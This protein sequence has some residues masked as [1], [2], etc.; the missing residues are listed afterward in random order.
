[1]NHSK[2]KGKMKSSTDSPRNSRGIY[3]TVSN[4]ARNM[5]IDFYLAED[6]DGQYLK[7]ADSV[8]IK[9]QTARSI[10]ARFM[11]DGQRDK[12]S[13]GG[14]RRI[15]MDG[16]MKAT[17]L[18]IL[19]ENPECS[20]Q[21]INELLR[22]R[23]PDKVVSERTVGRYLDDMLLVAVNNI[24]DGTHGPTA[25][26]ECKEQER[27][28]TMQKGILD[29]AQMA[30]TIPGPPAMLE[31]EQLVLGDNNRTDDLEDTRSLKSTEQLTDGEAG[32]VVDAKEF[33]E[34]SVKEETLDA[35][36]FSEVSVKEETLDSR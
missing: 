23:L 26:S 17:L 1:M 10:I 31:G 25:T 7:Y 5:L 24:A 4:K 6:N 14:A 22:Q 18:E 15:K 33:S 12:Q 29:E 34:V 9:R 8:G 32:D 19:K 11:R 16:G 35:K 36:E 28:E 3:N 2:T 27:N 30:E 20:M 13:R 21:H